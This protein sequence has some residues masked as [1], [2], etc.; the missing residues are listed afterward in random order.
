MA[1]PTIEAARELLDEALDAMR[2]SIAGATS[3]D[4]N[5]RPAGEDTNSIAALAT[6]SMNSTRWWL[7]VAMGED[8]P[9][10]DRPTEFLTIAAGVDE[11]L[12]FFDATA[13]D[14][15]TVLDTDLPF[16]GGAPRERDGEEK[17]TAAWALLHALEHLRE[18]V[19]HV[20]LTRQ[21]Q[22]F[23]AS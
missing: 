1:D 19:G 3:D 5:Q 7:Y 16:H 21:V 15:R 22:A 10:R 9:A 11:L 6:H 20:E 14:C 23:D 17:V 2:A 8:P 18:H 4:L 12:S 13:A